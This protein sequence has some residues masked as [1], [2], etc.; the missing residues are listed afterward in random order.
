MVSLPGTVATAAGTF[1]ATNVDALIL[2][3]ILFAGARAGSVR[4]RQI[5]LGQGLVFVMLVGTSIGM[6]A[7][8]GPVPLRWIGV[9]GLVPIT[10]GVRGLIAARRRTESDPALTDKLTVVVALALSVCAD[11]LSVYIVLFR[12]QTPAESALSVAVFVV[13]EV[14]WCVTAYT[15]AG[16]KTVIL[17]V[18]RSGA[19]VVP[20]LFLA[21]GTAILV[22]TELL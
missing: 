3:V 18:R 6:A 19:W 4:P 12:V 10:M 20:I 11:N 14:V 17:F 9:L 15:I 8:L 22:R 7:A 1:A 16:R 2:L 5:V 13:L 21:L